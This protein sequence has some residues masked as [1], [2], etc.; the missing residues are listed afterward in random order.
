M[1]GQLLVSSS[2]HLQHGE[3]V[4]R[5]MCR[6]CLALSPA[7]VMGIYFFGLH[8][9]LLLAVGVATAIAAELG[10]LAMRKKPLSHALDGSAAITGMLL[11]MVIPPGARW[12]C[13]VVGAAFAIAVAKHCFGGLGNNIWNPALAGRAFLQFAYPQQISLSHWK[14]P[15]LLWGGGVADATSGPSP[16]SGGEVGLDGT[17][18]ADLLFGNG[19]PGS[20]GE[21]CKVALLLGG[22][23][24]ILWNYIDWRVPLFYVGT[25]FVLTRFLP[26]PGQQSTYP[27]WINDPF[28]HVLSGGLILGAFFMATDMVTTPVTRLGRIVFAVG[29]GLLTAVIRL[30]GGYPEGVCYSILMMNTVTPL[31]DRWCRPAVYGSRTPGQRR[32]P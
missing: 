19:V 6:V 10:C 24:L 3:S 11:V 14:A 2:P 8:A 30:Y 4:R 23:L 31:I 28:Y 17:S 12:Y 13:A 32:S 9:L 5:I 21:T 18:Y 1:E 7:A 25:V 20:L 26:L 29:C 22:A 16:L 15:Q 27:Y